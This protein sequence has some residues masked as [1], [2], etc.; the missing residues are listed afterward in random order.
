MAQDLE[1]RKN[2][3]VDLISWNDCFFVHFG[4]HVLYVFH[5]FSV[6]LLFVICHLFVNV[7]F[8]FRFPYFSYVSFFYIVI[9][10]CSCVLRSFFEWFIHLR[11]FPGHLCHFD[12]C[13]F[14]FFVFLRLCIDYLT[15][16][17]KFLLYFFSC[18]CSFNL[19]LAVQKQ[20]G[21]KSTSEKRQR[22][23]KEKTWK[24]MNS[25]S[26]FWRC[27]GSKSAALFS[28]FFMYAY[29]P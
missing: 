10:H 9:W 17:S 29:V 15:S 26:G 22:R 16:C 2:S 18:F 25:V 27:R 14:I 12:A 11:P 1:P 5:V 7:V 28:W 21:G 20:H 23:E 8:V 3:I 24:T 19:L 6:P 13:S 4:F